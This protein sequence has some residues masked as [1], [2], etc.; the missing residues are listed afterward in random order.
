M[1]KDAKT[2]FKNQLETE[3]AKIEA[4]LTRLGQINPDDPEDWESVKKDLNVLE[5][6]ANEVADEFE[7]FVENKAVLNELEDRL[8]EVDHALKKI[9]GEADT[10][11]GICEVSGQEISKERLEANPAAR[12]HV[13]HTDQLEPLYPDTDT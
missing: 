3:K 13:E 10:E 7:E 8:A 1:E 4:D 9:N 6:D 12:A 2:H 11:Y 5:S